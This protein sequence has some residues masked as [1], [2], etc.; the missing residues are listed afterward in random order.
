MLQTEIMS[1]NVKLQGLYHGL[2][3]LCVI[4]NS[5]VVGGD[6]VSIFCGKFRIKWYLYAFINNAISFARAH[7]FD[8]I[9]IDWEFP[10]Q[11]SETSQLQ[12]L[13]SAFCTAITNEASS[14][15][16]PAL[17]LTTTSPNYHY[18]ISFFGFANI[19]SYLDWI[20]VMNYDYYGPWSGVV[21]SNTAF[22]GTDGSDIVETFSY[23][24]GVAANKL[25][26]GFANYA[27]TFT[28]SSPSK[29]TPGSPITGPGSPG[30]CTNDG[31][32]LNY[33]EVA[34]YISSHPSGT[35]VFDNVAKTPY[36]YSGNQWITYDNIASLQVKL[37]YL[38]TLGLK[39]GM[40]WTVD[41]N[42]TLTDYI[43]TK[44]GI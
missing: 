31:G 44:L 23:F 5:F 35:S 26:M 9:D 14:S 24:P 10:D 1:K 25:V 34:A 41:A 39:G 29:N 22:N 42:H 20:N 36:F 32:T 3:N 43:S 33:Y 13:F 7:S 17:L 18:A 16:K 19:Y 40:V 8:G 30:S 28:L 38:F 4:V 37:N 2:V 15:G 12:S 6:V 27:R 11:T 21:G